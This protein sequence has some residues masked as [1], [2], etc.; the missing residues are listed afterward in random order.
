MMFTLWCLC[1]CTVCLYNIF[2]DQYIVAH[3]SEWTKYLLC[4]FN[5]K[6]SRNSRDLSTSYHYNAHLLNTIWYSYLVQ[7]VFINMKKTLSLCHLH[8]VAMHHV[9]WTPSHKNHSPVLKSMFEI[10][11]ILVRIRIRIPESVPLTN[12]SGSGRPKNMRVRIRIPNTV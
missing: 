11:D 9:G 1:S 5:V 4:F 7:F 6:Q 12:T 10:R 8:D 3:I 2:A